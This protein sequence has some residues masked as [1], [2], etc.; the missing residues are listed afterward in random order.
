[1]G[2]DVTVF[3]GYPNY[4]SGRIFEGYIPKLMSKES[5]DGVNVIRSKLVAVPNTSV[6]KRLENALSY[7]FFGLFNII[8]C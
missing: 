3:T 5:I 8:F 4:P 1:M 7:F 2:H 6:I